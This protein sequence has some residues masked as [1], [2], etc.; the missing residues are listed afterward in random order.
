MENRLQ[1]RTTDLTPGPLPAEHIAANLLRFPLEDM[2]GP[3][4]VREK[5]FRTKLKGI[6]WEAYRGRPV[7]VP[8]IHNQEIPVWV[9]L[10]VVAR[11]SG[12]ASVLSFGEACSPTV[13]LKNRPS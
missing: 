5:D 9:Y 2:L 6:D 8:W 1:S 12:V 11:L 13:L 3:G 10:M 4:M 7:L